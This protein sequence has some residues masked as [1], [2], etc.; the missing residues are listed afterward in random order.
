M[1]NSVAHTLYD[2]H[3]KESLLSGKP[4]EYSLKDFLPKKEQP[5]RKAK[6]KAYKQ[7][8]YNMTIEDVLSYAQNL[9]NIFNEEKKKAEKEGNKEK[10]F[11]NWKESQPYEI[12]I[13]KI[14]GK[15]YVCNLPR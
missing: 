8:E 13:C 1:N 6:N 7:T 14:T 15:E 12:L 4:V 10:A 3:V 11:E 9:Y 2:N 5:K